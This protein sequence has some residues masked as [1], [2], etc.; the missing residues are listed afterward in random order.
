[1]VCGRVRIASVKVR[2]FRCLVYGHT[3]KACQGPD[4]S[5]SCRR[6]GELGHKAVTCK[7]AAQAVDAFARIL[8]AEQVS[9]KSS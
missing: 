5:E 6:C 9:T 2:C 8:G 4:R 7:A 3:R 1:M